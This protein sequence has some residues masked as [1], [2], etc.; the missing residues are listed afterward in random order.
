M[1]F[2]PAEN[3]V[4]LELVYDW[5]GETAE[6]TLYFEKSDGWDIGEMQNLATDVNEWWNENLAPITSSSV[7]LEVIRVTKLDT[8]FDLFYELA[9]A[10]PYQGDETDPSMP[11][12]VSVTTTFQSGKRGRSFR[13]RN[14]FVGLTENNV[15][16]N[17]VDPVF[18]AALQ[19]AYELLNGAISTTLTDHVVVSRF[20]NG[21]PRV[22][23]IVSEVIAYRAGQT[24]DTQRRRLPRNT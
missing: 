15:S 18:Q 22:D 19:T 11:N 14:Y 23:A 10:V 1:A 3:T 2:V 20:G 12:N 7:E 6:N 16:G 9:P 21:I 24:I 8:Q 17:L 4:L 13:G 5:Q